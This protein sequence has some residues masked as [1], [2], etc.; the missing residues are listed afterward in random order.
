MQT[1]VSKHH[2]SRWALLLLLAAGT[3]LPG[4]ASAAE[5]QAP[6][7]LPAIPGGLAV[8]DLH[9]AWQLAGQGRRARSPLSLVAA[10]DILA[11]NPTRPLN[12]EAPSPNG[13]P[14]ALVH[15]AQL[16]DEARA[17]ARGDR[18]VLSMIEQVRRRAARLPQGPFRGARGAPRVQRDA[19]TGGQRRVYTVTFVGREPALVRLA[20][21]GRSNLNLYVFDEHDNLV[22]SDTN[23]AD[24]GTALWTPA[25][26]GKF[27]IEVRNPGSAMNAYW[28]VTI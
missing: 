7:S 23:L 12:G 24:L 15:I 10:A 18:G 8:E 20:G 13:T 25:Q 5:C 21:S 17:M 28:L 3:P 1:P 22:S 14:P 19:V 9:L 16:L 27:R 11:S 4:G 26:T 2:P 6:G